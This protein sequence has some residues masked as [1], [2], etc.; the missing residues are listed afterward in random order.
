M[1][2]E[3]RVLSRDIRRL[4][5]FGTAGGIWLPGFADRSL[6]I[7]V[8]RPRYALDHEDGTTAFSIAEPP[9]EMI[10]KGLFSPSGLAQV[11]AMKWDL[12]VPLHRLPRFFDQRLANPVP[13]STT[14]GAIIRAAPLAA[15]LVR[16]MD[17]E[18]KRIAPYIA[19]DA[20]SAKIR[21]G[22][23]KRLK[24]YAW[25]RW[26]ENFA[27]FVNFTKRHNRSSVK[28]LLEGYVCP[29]LGDG[30]AVYDSLTAELEMDRGGCMSHAR[31]KFVF[32]LSSDGRAIVGISYIGEL[33]A[34]ERQFAALPAAERLA[35]RLK[36][37]LPIWTELICWRDE[38]L[39][40]S[41]V[42]QRSSLRQALGYLRNQESR[43]SYFLKDGSIKIHNNDT[44]LQ[45]RH[46][47]IGRKNWLFHG[48]EAGALAAGTWL[49]LVLSA[50][51]HRLDVRQ[52]LRDL[53]R[54]LPG[55]PQGRLLEL[56]PDRWLAT[57][58][59]LLE[60][61]LA[62]EFGHLTIPDRAL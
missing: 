28:S 53:F 15:E 11:I 13:K 21:F 54:V 32:A 50:R 59:R 57:R 52:Y 6:N 19:I 38:L 14:S 8:V 51:L 40:S 62:R 34:L 33:F 2:C 58:A 27:V 23:E 12:Q 29:M 49:S 60:K 48:S 1:P 45:A 24:G 43:L 16:A 55:W 41:S 3:K 31:R 36:H 10:P 17:E 7:A 4:L 9:H 37:S 61:E 20:T 25:F 5:N 18:A 35:E 46:Y 22:D 44:E 30:H 47:V 26:V 56:A 39:A 42:A